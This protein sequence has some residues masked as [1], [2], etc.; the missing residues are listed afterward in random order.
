MTTYKEEF[1]EC[2]PGCG[3]CCVMIS[4]SSAI[5]GMPNGKPAGVKCLHLTTEGLCSLFNTSQR[6]EICSKF[7]AERAICGDKKE[8]AYRN[9]ALLEGIDGGLLNI[10]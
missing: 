6:P 3:A 1:I 8:D 2:R 7:R 10:I 5:P 9:I 4:I